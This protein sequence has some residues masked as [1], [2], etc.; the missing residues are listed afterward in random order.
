MSRKEKLIKR[1]ISR[2]KDFRYNELRTLL[3]L[4]GYEE[5]KKGKT[6]GSRVAFINMQNR[7]IIRL[8][9][10]H[11]KKILKRYQID[12]IID[13]LRENEVI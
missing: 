1:L 2:P 4:L 8:H 9:R 5:L 10:P 3:K 13:T 7:H 12:Y 11:P 6:T